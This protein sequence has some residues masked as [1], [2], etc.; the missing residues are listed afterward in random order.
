[1]I[2]LRS[3]PERTGIPNPLREEGKPMVGMGTRSE[4]RMCS[5]DDGRLQIER[6]AR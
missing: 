5:R 6:R 2:L 4:K 1:M 3:S